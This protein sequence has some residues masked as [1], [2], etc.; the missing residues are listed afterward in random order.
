MGSRK[1][2]ALEI[3][4]PA[5]FL[6]GSEHCCLYGHSLG[7]GPD[8]LALPLFRRAFRNRVSTLGNRR[9]RT[10]LSVDGLALEAI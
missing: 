8:L 7:L 9:F 6:S 5:D 4:E 2:T 10:E 1:P 3:L